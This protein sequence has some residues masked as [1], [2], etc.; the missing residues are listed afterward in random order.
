MTVIQAVFSA[1][2]IAVCLGCALIVAG[3]ALLAGFG[4]ALIA[5]GAL[6]CLAAS[7]FGVVLL[8]EPG[9]KAPA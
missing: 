3:V 4:W 1:V 5:A 9:R 7:A 6:I 8:R 2:A